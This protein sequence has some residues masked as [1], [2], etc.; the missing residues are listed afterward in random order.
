MPFPGLCRVFPVLVLLLCVTSGKTVSSDPPTDS[1]VARIAWLGDLASAR[2]EAARSRRVL[3][4]QFTGS[5]CSNC[6][7]MDQ[8]SFSHPSIVAL[9][10]RHFVPLKLP[11]DEYEDLAG[12]L[13]LTILPATVLVRPTGQ[14]AALHQG[15][16][17]APSLHSFLS[18]CLPATSRPPAPAVP[19]AMSGHCPVSLVD[20][21]KLVP[22]RREHSLVHVGRR[23]RF[24]SAREKAAF[25][26]APERYAPVNDANCPVAQVD[27]GE[28]VRGTP[29]YGVLYDGHLYLFA[30]EA[31]RARFLK[32]PAR[33]AHV[34]A[35]DRGYC[36]HCWARDAVATRDRSEFSLRRDGRRTLFPVTHPRDLDRIA[37]RV[38]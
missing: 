7:R 25:A 26:R 6:V 29:S 3:W 35:V 16:L 34:D 18:A 20:R 13:G 4:I 1:R 27:R 28:V 24:A 17:D 22:G 14:V 36:P 10:D 31:Q 15:F 5:W 8:E 12:Q 32:Q 33:Y 21:H 30:G 37:T 19:L 9:A 11:A 23:Y 2:A 38:R